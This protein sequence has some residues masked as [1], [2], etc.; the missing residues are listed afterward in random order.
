MLAKNSARKVLYVGPFSATIRSCNKAN[1]LE[2]EQ[3]PAARAC[4]ATAQ[5][6]GLKPKE[7]AAFRGER[8][9]RVSRR[10]KRSDELTTC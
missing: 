3:P 8:P 10:P 1:Y 7:A 6:L 2:K 9:I 4:V 5:E